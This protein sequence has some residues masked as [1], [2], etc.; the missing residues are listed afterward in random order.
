MNNTE[1]LT[2]EDSIENCELELFETNKRITKVT[3]IIDT[4][5]SILQGSKNS[6][7]TLLRQLEFALLAAGEYKVP[8]TYGEALKVYIVRLNNLEARVVEL[9]EKYENLTMESYTK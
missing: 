5:Q 6:P 4:L 2:L 9:Q 8:A 1:E 3:K 7:F